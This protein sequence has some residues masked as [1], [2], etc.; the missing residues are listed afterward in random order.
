MAHLSGHIFLKSPTLIVIF[1]SKLWWVIVSEGPPIFISGKPEGG[2][3]FVQNT[4]RA[5]ELIVQHQA[6]T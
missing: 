3:G 6:N 5:L 2:D 1:F 4:S